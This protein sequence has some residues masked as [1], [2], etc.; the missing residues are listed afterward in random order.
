MLLSVWLITSLLY[1]NM[2]RSSCSHTFSRRS[3]SFLGLRFELD[4]LVLVAVDV[5][6]ADSICRMFSMPLPNF[7]LSGLQNVRFSCAN[8]GMLTRKRSDCLKNRLFS[9]LDRYLLESVVNSF[10]DASFRCG[11]TIRPKL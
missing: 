11:F 5:V 9:S 7:S 6:V 1:L 4:V 10:L 8:A 3:A 2:L